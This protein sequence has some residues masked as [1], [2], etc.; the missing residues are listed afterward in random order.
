[1]NHDDSVTE[2]ASREDEFEDTVARWVERTDPVMAWLGVLFALLVGFQLAVS[3]RPPA[4]RALDIAGWVIW[5]IFVVDFAAKLVLAPTKGRFL[6]RHWLQALALILP[7]LRLFSFLRLVRLGRAFP[8]ARV[9]TTSYRSIG[10]ARRLFRSRL[11]YLGG[12]S[13]IAVVG[14]AELA[15]VF[16][17]GSDG[18]LPTFLDSLIWSAS[19]V[20]GMQADPMPVTRLGQLVM[21]TGFAVGLV[22]IATLAGSF[23]AFLFE[24][25]QERE[26]TEPAR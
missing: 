15:Y 11:A 17:G 24:G 21:L 1:M 8:A 3:V 14:L 22:L 20:I 23:G 18:T 26:Q 5:A 2:Q 25:R 4:D 12:L 13:V 9:L 19:V 6:R 16:E 10:T 7:T